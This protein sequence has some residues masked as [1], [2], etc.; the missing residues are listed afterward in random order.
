MSLWLLIAKA[1]GVIV[2]L[3]V[4]VVVDVVGGRASGRGSGRWLGQR[5][6][7]TTRTLLPRCDHSWDDLAS[8]ASPK[9]PSLLSK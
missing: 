3:D 1:A 8:S 6:A 9:M 7:G 5:L 2:V 4:V